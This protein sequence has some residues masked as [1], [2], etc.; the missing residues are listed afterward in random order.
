MNQDQIKNLLLK[1]EDP[2][3]DFK[4]IFSGKSSKKVDGL[5]KPDTCE[6]IIHNKNFNDDNSLIYT[7]IHEYSHH[8]H[9]VTSAIP[10]KSKAH[11]VTFCAIFHRLIHKAEE[12]KIYKNLFKTDP[13]F[14][15]LTEI[16]KEKFLL[17]NSLIMKQFGEY[18]IKAEK[19]CLEKKMD[20]EYYLTNELGFPYSAGRII[21]KISTL[22]L[23]EKLGYE[24]MKIVA[25]IKQPE[26]AKK[27]IESF[28]EGK[29]I[30]EI[31]QEFKIK[32]EPPDKLKALT[33]EKNRILAT[34]KRLEIRLQE[35]EERIKKL[36]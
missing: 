16:I 12:K 7:A 19:L 30:Y 14:I 11:G 32:P 28:E 18:L 23:P 24:K 1:I 35:I 6:I 5:Y 10:I 22:N 26:V 8:I 34:I 25:S 2:V 20:F 33:Q 36:Y 17:K 3:K 15:K 27:V 29:S 9:S 4:V 21:M 13:D 31:R